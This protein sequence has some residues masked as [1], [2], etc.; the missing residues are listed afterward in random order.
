LLFLLRTVYLVRGALRHTIFR[1]LLKLEAKNYLG[2]YLSKDTATVVCLGSQGREHNVLGCFSVS[3]REQTEQNDHE[4]ATLIARGCAERELQFSEVAVAL[5]C[6]MF[7]QHNVHSDFNDPKKIAQTVRFDT[8]EALATDI[9]DIAIAFQIA[10]SDQAGSELSVFTAQRKILSDVL[11]SLQSNHI[12]PVTVEPDVSCLSRFVSQKVSIPED[13]HPLFGVLSRRSGYF[14]VPAS[15]GSKETSL[16]RTFLVGPAGSGTEQLARE[17]YVTTALLEN[18]EPINC[19]K[20]FDSTGSID[21][22]QLSEKLGLEASG[23]N[24][25]ESV[26]TEPQVL[27]DCA[28]PVDFTIAYGAAL[29]HLEKPQSIN[30]RSDFMPYQGKKRRLEKTLK[31]ASVSVTIL[32]LALGLYFQMPLLKRGEY[33]RELRRK[34]SKD[35]SAVMLGKP[36]P[37]KFSIAKRSLGSELKRIE[38]VQ[39]GRSGA[40][41]EES[42]MSKLTLV[43]E[44][45]NKCAAETNLTINKVHVTTKNIRIEGDTSSRSNTHKLFA[46]VR[47]QMI[48]EQFNYDLKGGRDN[49]NMTVV[50]KK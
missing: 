43:L 28:D 20:A 34:F 49:F 37:A 33:R 7:M 32:L 45:F 22:Q 16:M 29:A 14:V 47:E 9:S 18:E 42:M 17:V 25:A 5:D 31:F 26:A 13:S 44:A 12:D 19:L 30:F 41:G 3:V 46:A 40:T 38:N 35:Y 8:E 36:I 10:S 2:I 4:L 1:S 23:I 6:A 27:A 11:L 24:L 21:Y 48:I 50:P 39:S 15:S